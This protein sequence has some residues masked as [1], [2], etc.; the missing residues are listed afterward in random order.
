MAYLGLVLSEH[1]SGGNVRRGGITKASNALDRRVLIE[2]AWT[3]RMRGVKRKPSRWHRP[4]HLAGIGVVLARLQ[5][6]LVIQKSVEHMRRFAGELIDD[7]WH[8]QL[9]AVMR[10]ILNK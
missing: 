4:R 10:A 6:G 2:G 8:A 9:A 5:T 7:V 1:S 3:Y